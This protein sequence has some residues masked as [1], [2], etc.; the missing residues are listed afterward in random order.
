[1]CFLRQISDAEILVLFDLSVVIFDL[2]GDDL[3][4][5]AFSRP[6]RTD[7]SYA[8]FGPHDQINPRKYFLDPEIL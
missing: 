4:K 6:I 5:S 8:I 7:Y 3:E 2:P 1:M